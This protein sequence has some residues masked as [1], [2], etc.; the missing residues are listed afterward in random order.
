[1]EYHVSFVLKEAIPE[2]HREGC[3]YFFDNLL[4]G[5]SRWD[6]EEHLKVRASYFDSPN[7]QD[8]YSVFDALRGVQTVYVWGVEKWASR[9][10][11]AFVCAHRSR[12][13][14]GA[15]IATL[16]LPSGNIVSGGC[17]GG[18]INVPG[19]EAERRVLNAEEIEWGA[20]F[21][22][23]YTSLDP[24]SLLEGVLPWKL[25]PK[26]K[27]F[28]DFNRSLFPRRAQ[29]RNQL[30]EVDVSLLS[31]AAEGWVSAV[32][33]FVSSSR[34]SLPARRWAHC[35]GDAVLARRLGAWSEHP[36]GEPAL[37]VMKNDGSPLFLSR[38]RLTS[39]GRLLLEELSDLREAPPCA[40]GG[41]LAY[42]VERPFFV[43]RD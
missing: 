10:A 38:Y 33:L 17:C 26:R 39:K 5:P 4:A 23:A 9:L 36:L 32:E 22:Q 30:S 6:F 3:G 28:R 43:S 35:A 18:P 27:S 31:S 12:F 1:M 37:E 13:F 29:G 16:D 25:F 14:G 2:S 34:E 15:N 40:V 8:L 7:W 42:D 21:W 11:L 19:K 24:Q 20:K 41:T